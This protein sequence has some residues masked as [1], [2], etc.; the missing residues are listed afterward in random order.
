[1]NQVD[2]TAESF[3]GMVGGWLG[4]AGMSAHML[5][6][7]FVETGW[8]RTG[9][10][11][12]HLA[13]AAVLLRAACLATPARLER[14]PRRSAVWM[15]AGAVVGLFFSWFTMITS[16]LLFLGAWLAVRRKSAD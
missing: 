11:V 10:I 9:G 2:R 4:V 1:M 3:C 15:A 14:H 16:G 6:I 13:A 5:E 7:W 12:I 8:V